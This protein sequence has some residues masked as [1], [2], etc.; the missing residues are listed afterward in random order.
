MKNLIKQLVD[1]IAR[2]KNNFERYYSLAKHEGWKMHLMHLEKLK[3]LMS[4]DMLSSEFTRLP[5]DEKDIRQRTY[6]SVAE[7]LNFLQ[8]PFKDVHK[9][10][11][12]KAVE[13]KIKRDKAAFKPHTGATF[14]KTE[15][16]PNGEPPERI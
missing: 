10:A 3:L 11:K 12:I 15:R 9:K 7:V 1:D 16:K 8:Q 2:D 5:P 14:G 6:A 13:Q 4:V